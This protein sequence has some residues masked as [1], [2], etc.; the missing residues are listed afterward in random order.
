MRFFLDFVSC[1]G[2]AVDPTNNLVPPP[3][4]QALRSKKRDAPH[5]RPSLGS[6]SEDNAPPQRERGTVASGGD[7]KRRSS[8]RAVAAATAKAHHRYYSVDYDYSYG[9]VAMST[10][11]PT[12][13]PT[14]FMF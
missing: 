9:R 14:P 3:P 5:W 2:C 4:S 8:T 6:I 13:S 7:L 10:I 11:V 12:F 1:C